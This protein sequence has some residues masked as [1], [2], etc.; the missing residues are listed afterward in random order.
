ME[1]KTKI[2]VDEVLIATTK[3]F[4]RLD[5]LNNFYRTV[6]NYQADLIN[7]HAEKKSNIRLNDMLKSGELYM[8]K[9]VDCIDTLEKTCKVIEKNKSELKNQKLDLVRDLEVLKKKTNIFLDDTIIERKYQQHIAND[10]S[11]TYRGVPF[12]TVVNHFET[13]DKMI[14]KHIKELTSS[15]NSIHEKTLSFQKEENIQTQEQEVEL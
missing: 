5:A 7:E 13:K 15:L 3:A 9:I 10:I 2:L 4:S 14:M 6:N 1:I 11:N 12:E 8:N